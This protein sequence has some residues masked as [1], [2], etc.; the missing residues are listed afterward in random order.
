[1]FAK[2]SQNSVMRDTVGLCFNGFRFAMPLVWLLL[3]LPITALEN[4][5]VHPS[6]ESTSGA[7]APSLAQVSR[8]IALSAGYLERACGPDGKFA[9]KVDIGSGKE[10]H[11]YDIIR[12]AGA[13]YALAMANGSHP[14]PQAVAA[15]IRAAKFLR[16]DYIG[17]GIRAGQKVVWSQPL[18][19]NPSGRR[20]ESRERY[21]EL[22]GTGLGLVALA[23]ARKVAPQLVPIEELQALGRFVVFLQR[24]DGSF[25]HKYWADTGA[26]SKW[27]SLYYPGEAALGLIELYETDH[28]P[29]W[30][31]A[32]GKAL[33]YLAKSRTGI[34]T[35]PA[36]H[37]AL[38]ATAK[39][40]PY[41]DKSGCSASREELMRHAAQVCESILRDQ[42]KG[43]AAAGLD[44]AFDPTGRT[45]PTATRLEG[46]LAS[47]EF[48][49]KSELR[50]RIRVAAGRGIAFLLR[51][52]I[53]FGP[54][55]GG[56]PG[57]IIIS[58]R[59]FSQIRIDYVQHALCA[60]LR[61][62][63]L[64]Q[65]GEVIVETYNRP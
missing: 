33:S 58:A 11:S 6:E 39:L 51:A 5:G 63:Q 7:L 47:L 57:A 16:E 21:A 25:V 22:G 12:H 34:A 30:L 14:D 61:Y 64:F 38:I 15:L 29:E 42:F 55:A 9:Y 44:G 28:S 26:V 52:Q 40:I 3:T 56:M 60:W 10:S 36:D 13:M 2:H 41:C 19:E 1:M 54:E 31:V 53:V 46:L 32:A 8:A 59:D 35:V 50:E 18:T 4:T 62:G 49:P 48:L 37:W 27:E 24:D 45:A 65:P 20:F 43:S 17:A 23:S